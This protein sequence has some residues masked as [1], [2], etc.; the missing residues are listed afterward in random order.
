MQK[1]K[2]T[3]IGHTPEF[4]EGTFHI[5]KNGLA[6]VRVFDTQEIITIPQRYF[7]TALHK[8]TVSIE[9]TSK[10]AGKIVS[11]IRRAQF[12]FAGI[13]KK[14]DDHYILVTPHAYDPEIIIAST[15]V[16]KDIANQKVFVTITRWTPRGPL[17]KIEKVL[18]LPGD[19]ATE[20]ESLALE[21]G[22]SPQFPHDVE[23]EADAWE[24]RGII[25]EDIAGR[26]DFRTTPTWTIDPEDAKDFDDAL[27]FTLLDHGYEIGIH[28]ADVSYYVTKGSALDREASER[29]T[30][31]YLVD[32]TIPML[33]EGLSNNL[34]SLRPD[35][36]K[37][38]YS[39]VF[40]IDPDG[41]IRDTWMG[42]TIIRSQKRFT[43]TEA[44]EV[45][46]TGKG[47][48][49][50]ELGILNELAHIYTQQRFHDGALSLE[51]P[52]VKFH[53]DEQGVP[54]H[55]EKKHRID[56]QKLIEE[57]M[58]L[59]NKYVAKRISENTHQH[60]GIYRVHDK[61][62]PEK[63]HELWKYLKTLGYTVTYKNN[64]IPNQELNALLRTVSNQDER[65]TLQTSIVRSMAKAVYTTENIGHYGLGFHYYTH[66]TS[67]IRRYPDIVAHRILELCL[68]NETM[69]AEDF[70]FLEHITKHSSRREKDA[71]EAEWDSLAYKQ[72]EYMSHR[73]GQEFQGV[74]TSVTSFGM[75]V[76]ERES[77]A[78]GLIRY[79]DIP[80]DHYIFNE[81]KLI[82]VGKKTKQEFRIGTAVNIKVVRTDL[83]KGTIDYLLLP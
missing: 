1:Q 54:L 53:L 14:H 13:L 7:N 15:E 79:R 68:H 31:V 63:M 32:R 81:E 23:Q 77:L 64:V 19:N 52:E 5:G 65:D 20:M 78:E 43:Y 41:T 82:A 49:A 71:Q 70:A 30:S 61:P 50:K 48:F 22:F 75:F 24:K 2:T 45:I 83:S 34:C 6:F 11:I 55:V 8:D 18:G 16:T 25:D 47:P 39:V 12:G 51:S 62:D 76:R 46:D 29:T 3:A 59:A 44:Q 21:R 42:R 73:I 35:E 40:T 26:R 27:S 17:G 58:L 60:V 36:D 28:I 37:L 72:V 38:T 57:F 33:P 9:K 66:F 74:V 69:S 80:G 67:P 56:T 4:L 10:D